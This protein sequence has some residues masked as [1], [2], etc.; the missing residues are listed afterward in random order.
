[1]PFRR[2]VGPRTGW[3]GPILGRMKALD[4][5]FL[6]ILVCPLSRKPLVQLGEWLVSTDEETRRRYRILEDG[7]PVLLIEESEEM[8]PEDWSAAL[9]EAGAAKS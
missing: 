2:R 3:A 4:P 5:E 7:T 6:A 8:N 9:K 1:M